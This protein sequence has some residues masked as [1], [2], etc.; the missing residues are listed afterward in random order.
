ME[1]AKKHIHLSFGKRKALLEI[2]IALSQSR[3][4]KRFSS[5]WEKGA[6]YGVKAF[7]KG[8]GKGVE[9]FRLSHEAHC[10]NGLCSL[11]FTVEC[12]GAKS[13]FARQYTDFVPR[14]LCKAER[15][16]LIN[17]VRRLCLRSASLGEELYPDA[18][19]R[20]ERYFL[21]AYFYP[22]ANGS[23]V[24]VYPAGILTRHEKRFRINTDLLGKDRSR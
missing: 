23:L 22:A 9:L 1:T 6:V 18:D 11:V 13:V 21:R 4:G 5:M 19:K 16:A 2:P 8:K 3:D 15:R 24:V 17:E 10:A 12:D 20:C 7:M 14:K